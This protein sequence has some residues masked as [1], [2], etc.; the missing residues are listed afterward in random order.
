MP[1][2]PERRGSDGGRGSDTCNHP[3]EGPS[4]AAALAPA[5]RATCVRAPTMKSYERMKRNATRAQSRAPAARPADARPRV[6]GR[7]ATRTA[8]LTAARRLFARR[9][10]DGTS[11]RAITHE[12]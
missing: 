4:T 7:P 8:L 1:L 9:G 10:Y 5:P 6:K 12:A 2:G 11:V 3:L